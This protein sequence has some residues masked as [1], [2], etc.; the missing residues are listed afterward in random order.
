MIFSF[1]IC[2]ENNDKNTLLNLKNFTISNLK[3]EHPINR[4]NQTIALN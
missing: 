3:E 4:P 2:P 1:P